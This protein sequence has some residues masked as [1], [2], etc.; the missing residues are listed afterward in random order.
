MHPARQAALDQKQKKDLKTTLEALGFASGITEKWADFLVDNAENPAIKKFIE[1]LQAIYEHYNIKSKISADHINHLKSVAIEWI[2]IFSAVEN[3]GPSKKSSLTE[4]LSYWAKLKIT[5]DVGQVLTTTTC[6][7]SVTGLISIISGAFLTALT[8]LTMVFFGA[9]LLTGLAF[10]LGWREWDKALNSKKLEIRRSCSK[11]QLPQNNAEQG[12]KNALTHLITLE[13]AN[14]QYHM[15]RAKAATLCGI[16]LKGIVVV[17]ALS[18]AGVLSGGIIPAVLTLSLAAITLILLYTSLQD[19]VKKAEQ[20]LRQD[21]LTARFSNFKRIS[22]TTREIRLNDGL[23]QYIDGLIKKDPQ[24]AASLIYTLEKDD[25]SGFKTAL[26]IQRATCCL[27]KTAET[28]G[29]K[30][31]DK[32]TTKEIQYST[33][34]RGH[35]L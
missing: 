23:K 4:K 12:K 33:P 10:G 24:K 6:A 15:R 17:T 7:T 9:A 28:R 22:E 8:A 35:Y 5:L 20:K 16:I 27:F 19:D 26:A 34:Y 3:S 13:K 11:T 32:L 1:F 14:A 25:K 21:D 18:A 30:I 29:T 31:Y 2:K